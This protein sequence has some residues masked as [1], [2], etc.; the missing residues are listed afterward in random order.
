MGRPPLPIGTHG[1]IRFYPVAGGGFRA[2]TKFRDHDGVTR[3]VERVG[4]SR[5]AAERNL[6]AALR[7]RAGVN[8]GSTITGDTRFRD[9]A[10]L[11]FTTITAAVD[12]GRRS[13][14]T[15]DQYRG[16][17]DRCVLP[18]LGALRVREV[19]V[20]RIDA[21]LTATGT[22]RGASSAKTCRAVISGVLGLAVRHGA[23]PTNPTR[24]AGRIEAR[25]KRT[26]RALTLA[27]RT[28]WLAQLEADEVAVGKDLP[29][30]SRFMLAT[31][32]RIGET[33]A[34]FWSDV[35]FDARTVAVDHTVI[36]VKG[37]GLIR[38]STKSQAGE[39]TLPLPSWAL[40]MLHARHQDQG[41]PDDGPV[42]PDGLGGMRDPSNTRRDL[43][44]ARGSD[45]F[46]WVTSHVFRKTAATILDDAGLS[47]RLVADQLGHARP[48]MTQDVY[49][50][51][52]AVNRRTADALERA[53]GAESYRL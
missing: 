6:K 13:P 8:T 16:H 19:T 2:C 36:R 42:F 25:R 22:N 28:T 50:G 49:M 21:F 12:Q 7:D 10:E 3:P 4:K 1:R 45:G 47:A 39:R 40:D 31:G 33:L 46:A 53:L 29:D 11:W 23:L 18:G 26:P 30:L 38:K 43:R 32:V 34:V 15:A 44:N 27:E 20:P 9:V 37:K 51:R 48:S 41:N 24:D 5:A 17:L 52:K 14:G 35:D